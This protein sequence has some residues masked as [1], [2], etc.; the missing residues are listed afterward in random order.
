MSCPASHSRSG[1]AFPLSLDIWGRPGDGYRITGA[2][3]DDEQVTLTLEHQ[4]D[5]TLVGRL[6]VDRS[7]RIAVRLDT[8]T[9][10]IRYRDIQPIS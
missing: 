5:T 3:G 1:W 7:R 10:A 6:V 2:V 8:P 4:K 9:L